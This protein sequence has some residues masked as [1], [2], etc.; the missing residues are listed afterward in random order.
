M[1]HPIELILPTHLHLLVLLGVL[2]VA[3]FRQPA[4]TWLNRGRFVWAVLFVWAYG[5]SMP[6]VADAMMT[7]LE[8]AVPAAGQPDPAADPDTLIIVLS[9]G[10]MR[11]PVGRTRVR[12]DTMGWERVH[13][14]V[15]L[16]RHTGGRMVFTGGPPGDPEASLAGASARFARELG[17]PA[18][19]VDLSAGAMNTQQ[20]LEQL[21]Q[22]VRT[23]AGP[24]WLVTSALHMPRA[25]G[26]ADSLGLK[27]MA[28]PV[29]F[30]QITDHS[31]RSWVPNNGT[32]TR[33]RAVIHE[34]IGLWVYRLRKGLA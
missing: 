24:V 15:Q 17:V 34:Y 19:D 22:R 26:I 1:T 12:F 2:A 9:S 30:L 6:I 14:G 7:D 31:W 28:W 8:G 4:G 16:W 3:A 21:S 18:A 11:T 20:E 23:H 25:L 5:L 13:G 29:G 10:E 32:L 27:V 33:A